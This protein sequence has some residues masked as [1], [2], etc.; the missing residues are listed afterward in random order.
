VTERQVAERLRAVAAS[1]P[2]LPDGSFQGRGVVICA[3]GPRMLACAWVC[4]C[5]L[6]RKLGCDLPIQLW[7]L[8]SEELPPEPASAFAE[9]GVEAVDALEVRREH[10]ARMLG[11]W[12]LKPYA[13]VHSPFREVLVLDADNVA[14]LDP[15]FLFETEQF[16]ATGALFWPDTVQ[17]TRDNGLWELCGVAY[18]S[19]PAWETGQAVVDKT[20]CWNALALTLEMNMH[21]DVVF[22]HSQGDKDTFHLAWL[23]LD[24]PYAMTPHPAKPIPGRPVPARLR[25]AARLP[26][27]QRREVDPGRLEPAYARLP[28]RGGVPRV[29]AGA[30]G[31]L[32]PAP[33]PGRQPG[34]TAVRRRRRR[35]PR[36]EPLAP[37][38]GARPPL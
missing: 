36:P 29:P 26:A 33:E 37:R 12:E 27:P 14:V 24:Q 4:V 11:G 31:A 3:G 30:A 22:R 9:L 13:L 19:E 8:G 32:D 5:M 10:P 35:V 2:E 34:R 21:S 6:R 17:L 1:P 38:A 7:H 18:Q 16:A 23:M 28:P 15:A 25:R 20:R